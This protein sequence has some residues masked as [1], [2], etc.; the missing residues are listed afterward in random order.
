[1]VSCTQM[2]EDGTVSIPN[3]PILIK[4][5]ANVRYTVR[6]SGGQLWVEPKDKLKVRMGSS[7]DR[8]DAL[9]LLLW[10]AKNMRS[11]VR[12]YNRMVR[13]VEIDKLNTGH[14]NSYGWSYAQ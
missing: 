11:P 9:I 2:F 7:P 8:A 3:D 12:D 1:M 10:Q 14:S 13:G 5:L 4:Q 6:G